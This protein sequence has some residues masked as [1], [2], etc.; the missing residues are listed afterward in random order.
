MRSCGILLHI[1][2]L[3]SKYGIG[4]LG[5]SAYNFIDFLNKSGQSYWQVLPIGATSFGDSPYQSFSAFAGNPLLID[6]DLLINDGL[7]SQEAVDSVDFSNDKTHVDYEKLFDKKFD[8]LKNSHINFIA[9]NDFLAFN[10]FIKENEFWINDYALFMALKYHFNQDCW[11][12]WDDDIRLR[13]ASAIEHYTKLLSS[14]IDFWKYIQFIFFAQ[15]KKLTRYA[16]SADIKIFGDIPIYVSMDSVDLWANTSLFMLDKEKKPIKVAGCPPDSFS[17]TGQLWGNPLY[18]W[19]A[20][21]K[22]DFS[23]WIKRIKAAAD[24]FDLT[25]ID[26]FRGFDSFYAIA[27]C[28]KTAEEGEWLEGPKM[29]L[30]N[31]IKDHL[32]KVNLV[33]ENLGFLTD[34]VLELLETTGYPGMNVL[35]FAFDKENESNYMPHNYKKESVTYIGTHDNDTCVGYIKSLDK[36]TL[37]FAR[38]YMSLNVFEGYVWGIIRTV[39]SSVSDLVIVQMQ[40]FLELGSD[41]RMNIPS[42]IGGNWIWRMKPTDM[43]DKLADKIN[44]LAKT[45]FR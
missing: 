39:Y 13:K 38:K 25:R 45:Y 21:E 35:E 14:Q 43:S 26:H 6:I 29:K 42:T 40:D 31:S 23:W 15:W 8:L 16:K 2:S 41:A 20:M 10:E 34:S 24:L 36:E 28:N 7:L 12:D 44:K 1:S 5:Q 11:L 37:A 32:G 30:F 4:S 17:K 22:D 9:K 33:A 3:P 18:D 19:E 27:Y